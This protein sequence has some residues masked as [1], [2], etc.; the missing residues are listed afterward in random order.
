MTQCSGIFEIEDLNS[1]ECGLFLWCLSIGLIQYL[2]FCRSL[3]SISLR[4]RSPVVEKII[5]N[6]LMMKNTVN[7]TVG[8]IML[9]FKIAAN[10]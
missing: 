1:A 7:S 2:S 10:I 4:N 8:Y 6:I 9:Q 5:Q 3:T